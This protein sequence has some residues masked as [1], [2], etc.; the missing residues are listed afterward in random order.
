M[1]VFV[2]QAGVRSL[3]HCIV[4][5]PSPSPCVSYEHMC[6]SAPSSFNA[7]SS[8]ISRGADALAAEAR[9]RKFLPEELERLFRAAGCADQEINLACIDSEDDVIVIESASFYSLPQMAL[10]CTA[11]PIGG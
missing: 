9:H 3:L 10:N 5:P 11:G 8:F 1:R 4:T 6:T 2:F 7:T